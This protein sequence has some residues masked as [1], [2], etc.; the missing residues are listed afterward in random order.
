MHRHIVHVESDLRSQHFFV[1][2]LACD[3]GSMAFELRKKVSYEQCEVAA[4]DRCPG[5]A[6]SEDLVPPPPHALR[7]G[8]Q[9]FTYT[10]NIYIYKERNVYIDIDM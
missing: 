2:D 9:R 5:G 8:Q 4:A 1:D 6:V 10:Y 7:A 3:V